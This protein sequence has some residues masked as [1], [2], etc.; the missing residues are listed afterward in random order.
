[1]RFLVSS[2][3]RWP[4]PG[5]LRGR[6]RLGGVPTPRRGPGH[7]DREAGETV[8]MTEDGAEQRINRTARNSP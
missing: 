7:N 5:H 3:E 2:Y 4:M 8:I 6:P 1:V